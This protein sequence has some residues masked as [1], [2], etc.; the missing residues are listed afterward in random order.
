[1]HDDVHGTA[2]VTLAAALVGCNR[3]DMEFGDATVGQ[4]GLG[5]AGF[6]IAALM[7]AAGAERVHRQRPRTSATHDA[8]ARVRHR[9]RRT[10]D[11]LMREADVVVAT[12]GRPGLIEPDHVRDGQ[13]DPRADEP[14]ARRSTPTPR[15]RPARRS[16]PTASAVNNV[17]GYPGIFRGALLAGAELD[18][19]AR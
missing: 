9:D 8:R 19:H 10:T 13:V 12:T 4:I 14:R 11:E 17:L 2:V 6:G 7:D 18:Q 3:A 5:A 15:S 16:P 1:M